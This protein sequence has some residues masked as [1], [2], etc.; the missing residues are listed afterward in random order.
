MD[1]LY[2][3]A[4]PYSHPDPEVREQRFVMACE[5]AGWMMSWGLYV[6]SPIAHTHPISCRCD[7]PKGFDFWEGYDSIILSKCNAL[8]VV[9]SDGWQESKGVSKEID[10]ATDFGIPVSFCPYPNYQDWIKP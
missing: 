10:L 4:T 5:I 6:F 2:Y 9:K 1:K 7:L 3:L 8:I